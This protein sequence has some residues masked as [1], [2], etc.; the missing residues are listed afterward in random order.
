MSGDLSADEIEALDLMP[1]PVRLMIKRA[2]GK[3][4]QRPL[5]IEGKNMLK[6]MGAAERLG[7]ITAVRS[8]G[9]QVA[10]VLTPLGFR[11]GQHLQR[12]GWP[13]C[14]KGSGLPAVGP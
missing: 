2:W 10:V 9:L 12:Q 14:E 4:M 1:R 7:L 5:W 11:L 3:S 13:R 6:A 8:Y